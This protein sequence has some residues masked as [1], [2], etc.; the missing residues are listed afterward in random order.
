MV[1]LLSVASLL[2][3]GCASQNHMA[4][5]IQYQNSAKYDE[6]IASYRKALA[7]REK[8]PVVFAN[9]ATCYLNKGEYSSAVPWYAKAVSGFRASSEETTWVLGGESKSRSQMVALYLND[10]GVAHKKMNT[11]EDRRKAADLFRQ[12]S[13]VDPTLQIASDNLRFA[14]VRPGPGK[15]LYLDDEG[16][17]AW[18]SSWVA[19]GMR[20]VQALAK[21]NANSVL[22]LPVL[23]DQSLSFPDESALPLTWTAGSQEAQDKHLRDQHKNQDIPTVENAFRQ[24]L[25]TSNVPVVERDPVILKQVF[26]EHDFASVYSSR[27]ELTRIGQFVEAEAIC[28]IKFDFAYD[29]TIEYESGAPT[30]PLNHYRYR[31]AVNCIDVRTGE[32]VFTDSCDTET[33]RLVGARAYGVLDPDYLLGLAAIAP[34]L[35]LQLE[36]TTINNPRAMYAKAIVAADPMFADKLHE[37]DKAGEYIQRARKFPGLL[38]REW[39]FRA[40]IA[41]ALCTGDKARH[42]AEFEKLLDFTNDW[43]EWYRGPLREQYGQFTAVD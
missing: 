18:Q 5:G 14:M 16:K 42:Q 38:E 37:C 8:D 6:A 9:I 12:A 29:C 1:F 17:T 35:Y 11:E 43:S 30:A 3:H 13:Q 26:D 40:N 32:T 2:F 39:M 31:L 23:G 41:H 7:S 28:S 15:T 27:S 33:I 20:M 4:T 36:Q 25:V 24:L 22:L 34:D 19:L 10:W 21:A